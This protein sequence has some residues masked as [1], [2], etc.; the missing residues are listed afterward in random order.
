[1]NAAQQPTYNNASQQAKPPPRAQRM[2]LAAVTKGKQDTP[3]RVLVYG[4]EGVGKST[5]GGSAPAPIFIG[6]EDGTAHLD[7]ARFPRPE[8]FADVLEGI[9]VL[10]VDEHPYRTLVLDTL[11]WLEPLIWRDV[12][13]RDSKASSIEEVGGGYGKGYTAAVDEWRK[14]VGALERLQTAKR[15]HVVLLAHSH[16][17]NF[18]NPDGPDFDRYQLMLNDKAAG[19]LKQWC[20]DVLFARQETLVNPERYK[21]A[22]AV[23]VGE[24]VLHTERTAAFDAKNRHSLPPT[25]PLSWPDYETAAKAEQVAP[26]EALKEEI[27]QKAAELGGELEKA[28]LET[29]AKAGD[30]AQH[31]AVLLNRVNAKLAERPVSPEAAPAAE[32]G[33]ES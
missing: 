12:V 26:P 11:D 19:V 27:K 25:L 33:S 7:V 1:M 32:K 18:K 31:L 30:N 2:T 4:P 14:L 23:G 9:R 6:A 16:I 3:Y 10:A 22:K 8:S 20:D 21:K 29:A 13:A 24:R 17:K 15:M 28:V 5:F